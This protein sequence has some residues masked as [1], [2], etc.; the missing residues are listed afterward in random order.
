MK[1]LELPEGARLPPVRDKKLPVEQME[2]LSGRHRDVKT[3]YLTAEEASGKVAQL[4]RQLKHFVQLV[5]RIIIDKRLLARLACHV[6][7]TIAGACY[8]L[9]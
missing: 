2:A 7:S 1:K 8:T 9:S 6:S 3:A 4:Q 5:S